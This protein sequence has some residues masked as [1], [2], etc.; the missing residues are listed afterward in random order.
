MKVS[1]PSN[2][3]RIQPRGLHESPAK[4]AGFAGAVFAPIKLFVV[5]L[6]Q[7]VPVSVFMNWKVRW[8]FRHLSNLLHNYPGRY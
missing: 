2:T 6:I 7:A 3:S 1:K 4:K 8:I 5:G